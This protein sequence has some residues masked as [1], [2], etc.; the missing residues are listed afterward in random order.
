MFD[1][2]LNEGGMVFSVKQ[3]KN[4]TPSN[5]NFKYLTLVEVGPVFIP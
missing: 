2:I 1:R 3:T 4:K 5:Q